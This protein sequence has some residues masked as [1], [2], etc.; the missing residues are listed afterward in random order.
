MT[1][2]YKSIDEAVSAA[3]EAIKE[4][5][6]MSDESGE[7]FSFDAAY[8]MGGTYYPGDENEDTGNFWYPSSLSC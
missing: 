1:K 3:Y 4:A 2:K 5:E 6:M 8:G 7:E